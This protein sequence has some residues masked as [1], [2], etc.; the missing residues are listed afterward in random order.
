[1]FQ[2]PFETWVENVLA[3]EWIPSWGPDSLA[4]GAMAARPYAWY[5]VKNWPRQGTYN[6]ACY[7]VDDSTNY[8][9][10]VPGV[11]FDSTITAALATWNTIMANGG[12]IVEPA[13]R[14]QHRRSPWLG[15]LQLPRGDERPG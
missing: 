1:M 10:Y 7:N 11:T 9:R 2:V 6:G 5:F 8:Q 4:A 3:S 14:P 13:T 12:Q 15:T